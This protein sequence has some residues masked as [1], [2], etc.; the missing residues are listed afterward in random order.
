M[1]LMRNAMIVSSRWPLWAADAL[2]QDDDVRDLWYTPNAVRAA[3]RRGAGP[4]RPG[5]AY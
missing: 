1:W 3:G 5:R 4:R 2:G